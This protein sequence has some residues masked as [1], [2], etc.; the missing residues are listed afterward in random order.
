MDIL[1][2]TL[3]ASIRVAKYVPS[4]GEQQDAVDALWREPSRWWRASILNTAGIG[5]FSSDRSIAE[6]ARDIWHVPAL[7]PGAG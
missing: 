4:Y 7:H 6:Y 2:A 1:Q 3:A 5:W